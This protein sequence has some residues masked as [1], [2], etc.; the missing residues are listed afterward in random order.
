MKRYSY[1]QQVDRIK[2]QLNEGVVPVKYYTPKPE[3]SNSDTFLNPPPSGQLRKD[4]ADQIKYQATSRSKQLSAELTGYAKLTGDNPSWEAG[5]LD[6]RDEPVGRMKEAQSRKGTGDDSAHVAF[7]MASDDYRALRSEMEKNAEGNS[8]LQQDI[9]DY[10]RVNVQPMGAFPWKKLAGAAADIAIGYAIGKVGGGGGRLPSAVRN[11][12]VGRAMSSVGGVPSSFKRAIGDVVNNASA[13][14]RQ[15]AD[16]LRDKTL[17]VPTRA[18]VQKDAPHLTVVGNAAIRSAARQSK[19]TTVGQPQSQQ[20]AKLVSK[21][22]DAQNLEVNPKYE[23][24]LKPADDLAVGQVLPLG[25]GPTRVMGSLSDQEQSSKKSDLAIGGPPIDIPSGPTHVQMPHNGLWNTEIVRS[26][27]PQMSH[28][29]KNVIQAGLPEVLTGS[30]WIGGSKTGML[31]VTD[32]PPPRARP[33]EIFAN[34]QPPIPSKTK[35]GEFAR[36]DREGKKIVNTAS[37]TI[38]NI[39]YGT[40]GAKRM[41]VT[42]D[43]NNIYDLSPDL[44]KDQRTK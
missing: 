37:E 43:P 26:S 9:K 27:W 44:D 33:F 40:P 12:T 38:F 2:I 31:G 16:D 1:Q 19:A 14:T 10:D 4:F 35:Y 17:G 6:P 8:E 29:S 21:V 11:T 32:S 28:P 15:A 25:A 39:L 42:T 30:K 20:G 34:Q 13:T 36:L 22:L 7:K 23:Y 18:E 3:N 24:R 5:Q 41:Q